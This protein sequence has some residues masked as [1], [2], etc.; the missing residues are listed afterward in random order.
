MSARTVHLR[1]SAERPDA[2][3][4]VWPVVV[5][6]SVFPG[7]IT[8]MH[9]EWGGRELVIWQTIPDGLVEG[10]AGYL[11]IAP[12]NCVLLEAE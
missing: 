11:W 9:V 2:A 5:R 10:A 7:D 8:Q 12:G 4:N 6:C 3:V 1:L